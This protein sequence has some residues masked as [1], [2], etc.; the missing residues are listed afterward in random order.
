MLLFDLTYW[1]QVISNNF[2]VERTLGYLICFD[3]YF[4]RFYIV[5]YLLLLLLLTIS[6]KILK[7][8]F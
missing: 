7:A 2:I 6:F 5:L 1:Y 8:N 4:S 3:I